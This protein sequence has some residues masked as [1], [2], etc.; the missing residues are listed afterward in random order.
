MPSQG[1]NSAAERRDL[2]AAPP[3][4][5]DRQ[6]PRAALERGRPLRQLRRLGDADAHQLG[7]EVRPR[8]RR[9]DHLVE[10]ADPRARAHRPRLRDT[11][12]PT[13]R[14]RS[15]AS[16]ATACTST[17]A[18]TSSSSCYAGR[19]RILPGLAFKTAF[20]ATGDAE[21]INGFPC[22]AMS[23]DDIAE[24]VRQFA[25]AARRV[26]EAGLDGVE[27]AGANGMLFTQFLSPA[28]NDR[29]DEYG[30][31]L[32][33]RAR[34]ALE[35][36]RAIAS[37]GRRRLLPRLQDQRRRGP[38]R[39]PAVDA[40][41]QQRRRRRRGLPLARAGRRRLPP[42]QR[43]HR[44]PAPAQPGRPLPGQGRGQDLRRPD[45]ERALRAPELPRLPHLAAQRRLP[46]VVGAAAPQ[47]RHR[48]HQPPGSAASRRPCRSRSSARAAS[49][50]RR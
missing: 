28:I 34:F 20:G 23:K 24:V 32:E 45:L 46:L 50:P 39:A 2:R 14:S 18:S 16:S 30:G 44:L 38:A 41:G 10:R 3:R 1:R 13:T 22:S 48:G 27:L 12:T 15:G 26:R 19:E 7:R 49:R 5:A 33:N 43:R 36:V 8:R 17:T 9:R 31:S 42:R 35:V 11:S 40:E 29:K 25:E 37:R 6:E 21:P 47:A 4:P